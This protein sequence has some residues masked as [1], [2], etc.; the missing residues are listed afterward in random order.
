LFV[1]LA[2]NT[3]ARRGAILALRWDQVDLK[4]GRIDFNPA[5]R[6]QTAKRRPVVPINRPLLAALRKA[7]KAAKTDHVVEYQG[8]GLKGIRRAFRDACKAAGLADVTP[9][10]L[11]H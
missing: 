5:G 9:H 6:I 1:L 11:R 3:G 10:T 4:Q 8:E 2:L 7:K